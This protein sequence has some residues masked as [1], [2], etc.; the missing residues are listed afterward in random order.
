MTDNI[1]KKCPYCGERNDAHGVYKCLSCGRKGCHETRIFGNSGCWKETYS[2][3]NCDS[4]NIERI[5]HIE[6]RR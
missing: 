2:C 4:T 1:Y 6:A 5:G 3:P